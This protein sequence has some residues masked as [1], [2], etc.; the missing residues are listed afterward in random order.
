[1]AESREID[2]FEKIDAEESSLRLDQFLCVSETRTTVTNVNDG[3]DY[4]DLFSNFLVEEAGFWIGK[5]IG[6]DNERVRKA[7]TFVSVF[8]ILEFAENVLNIGSGFAFSKLDLSKITL[9]QIKETVER[10]EGKFDQ[11]L[12]AP[13]KN[14]KDH[15]KS[16]IS[17]VSNQMNNEA[18]QYFDKVINEATNALNLLNKKELTIKDFEGCTQAIQLLSFAKIARTSYDDKQ[19]H[20]LPIALLTE[21][22]IRSIGNELENF[23]K[24]CESKKKLVHTGWFSSTKKH[25]RIQDMLDTILQLSY[26]YISESKGWTR[27]R[28]NILQTQET[29]T[30]KIKPK[31][32]LYQLYT[33]ILAISNLWP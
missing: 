28:T 8:A 10:I 15:C 2:D 12:E 17:Y 22:K 25:L 5:K 14:A 24:D 19:D 11:L 32:M 29:L 1:M 7:V 23:V 31:Y 20:F 18:F 21:N 6:K 13:L 16:A 4:V 27:M 30:I 3:V 9:S 26:P 33:R